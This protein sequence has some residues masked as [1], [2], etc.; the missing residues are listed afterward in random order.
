MNWIVKDD[1]NITLRCERQ[2]CRKMCQLLRKNCFWLTHSK[3]VTRGYRAWG[4]RRCQNQNKLV[5]SR[6][7]NFLY[8]LLIWKQ[9]VSYTKHRPKAKTVSQA[10]T[11]RSIYRNLHNTKTAGSIINITCYI[12]QGWKNRKSRPAFRKENIMDKDERPY[13]FIL[14]IALSGW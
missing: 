11:K 13:L 12:R 2:F 10:E 8:V 1:A 6:G 7:L 3:H 9:K 14:N 4:E 5:F